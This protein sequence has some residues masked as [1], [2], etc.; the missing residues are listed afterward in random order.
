MANRYFMR[1]HSNFVHSSSSPTSWPMLPPHRRH[2]PLFTPRLIRHHCLLLGVLRFL[3]SQPPPSP[4]RP[5]LSTTEALPSWHPCSHP[6]PAQRP[7]KQPLLVPSERTSVLGEGIRSSTHILAPLSSPDCMRHGSQH[8][9]FAGGDAALSLP[10]EP[11]IPLQ[12]STAAQI[13][14]SHPAWFSAA[15][16][17]FEETFASEAAWIA[18]A[19]GQTMGANSSI[20]QAFNDSFKDDLE[21]RDIPPVVWA[22][23]R[24][25]GDIRAHPAWQSASVSFDA[26]FAWE[27]SVLPPIPALHP[28]SSINEVLRSIFAAELAVEPDAP[29]S[30]PHHSS[31][32][33]LALPTSFA[34]PRQ[35]LAAPRPWSLCRR[36][37]TAPTG[38]PSDTQSPDGRRTTGGLRR[39]REPSIGSCTHW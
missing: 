24:I 11:E 1:G 19:A 23:P 17:G 15:A 6:H 32:P 12:N 38:W 39:C 36:S 28:S 31:P 20:I 3:S 22:P 9:D 35:F 13:A 7:S 33:S 26:A 29:T 10:D 4:P 2:P 34:L 27:L 21:A 37:S 30:T 25:L 8:V 14:R 16:N 18:P 5:R